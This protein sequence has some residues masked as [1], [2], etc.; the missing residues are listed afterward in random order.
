MT[1]LRNLVT[2][3]LLVASLGSASAQINIVE[4]ASIGD[5]FAS[6]VTKNEATQEYTGW[7]IQLLATTD[8]RELETARSQ[9][10]SAYP[11]LSTNWSYTSPYYRL[12]VGAYENKIETERLLKLI[13]QKYPSAYSAKA[14]DIK[15]REF[16]Q[17][18]R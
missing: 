16:V 3:L 6:Y 10:L 11:N 13:R 9:F 5:L 17:A 7:R 8:R 2:A 4:S 18:Y 1:T 15:A 12:R 14:N